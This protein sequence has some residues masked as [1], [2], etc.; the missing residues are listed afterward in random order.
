MKSAVIAAIFALAALLNQVGAAPTSHI[1][2]EEAFYTPHSDD[3]R[4]I[5]STIKMAYKIPSSGYACYWNGAKLKNAHPQNF[6][7]IYSNRIIRRFFNTNDCLLVASARRGFTLLDDPD[8]WSDNDIYRIKISDPIISK[9][10]ATIEVRLWSSFNTQA[11]APQNEYDG[12]VILYMVREKGKW[13]I[14]NIVG[15]DSL[16]AKPFN[17]LI[18]EKS[19]KTPPWKG[20]DYSK[21]LTHPERVEEG[22][23]N[24]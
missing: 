20:M 18:E 10:R 2:R 1:P 8:L 11:L 15:T 23:S 4:N 12:G 14:D 13:L 7:N 17:S 9:D 21:S 19:W 5:L 6:L 24:Q 3:E 16:G 22:S